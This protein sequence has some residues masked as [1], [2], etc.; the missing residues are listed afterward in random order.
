MFKKSA[1]ASDVSRIL[2]Y[3]A[4]L[5]SIAAMVYLAGPYIAFGD[6]RPLENYLV[7]DIV[8][9]LLIAAFAGFSGVALWKRR[10]NAEALEEGI[11]EGETPDDSE[12][13][14][15]RM[16]DALATLKTASGGKADF[17]Y[18]LPW[19]VIIGPP[20]SGKTTALINSGLRFPLSNGATPQAI[21]GAG[22]TRYCDWWF[23]EE[24]VLIDT[25]GRY[26]TQDSDV[27]A[28]KKSWLAFLQL[29][30]KSRPNQPINGVL[31]AI[32]IQD[33]LLLSKDEIA[34]HTRAIRSRLIEIYDELKVDFPVYVLFTKAD[35]VAGFLEYFANF[36]EKDRRQVWGATFQTTDKTK[37]LVGQV[38]AE[39]DGLVNRLNEQMLDRLQEEPAPGPR[40][41]LYGLPAQMAA[42]KKPI[43]D[44]LNAIFEPTRYHANAT[45]RGFYFA[46]GTQEGTPIDQLIVALSRNFGAREVR[47]SVLSGLGKSFFLTDLLQKVIFGE[48]AWV[49]TDAKALL[50]RRILKFVAIGLAVGVAGAACAAWSIS[51][52]RNM[53]L[54]QSV[55]DAG[56]EYKITAGSLRSED[57]VGDRDF[58][59]IEP[60]L[61]KLRF[62]PAG[63]AQK[64]TEVP[65]AES[66]GLSQRPRLTSSAV[67]AYRAGLER[68]YRPRLLYRLEEVI[69]AKHDDPNYVYEALKV[70][71]MLGGLHAPDKEFIVSWMRQDWEDNLHPGA[72]QA[73]GRMALE[74][75]LR[76]M[77]DLDD[78]RPSLVELSSSVLDDSQRIL[79]RLSIAQRAYQLLKSNARSL[80]IPDWNAKAAGGFDSESVFEAASGG[81]L[82]SIRVPGFFT[83]A[84]F[85]QGLLDRLGTVADQARNEKWVLGKDAEQSAVASQYESV[86]VDVYQLY[87][88]E[89]VQ[90]WRA[91]L[92]KLRLRRLTADKPRYATLSTLAGPSSPL[93]ALFESIRDETAL[94]RERP[95]AKKKAGEPQAGAV[96]LNQPQIGAPGS[97][98]EAQ[99]RP[100]YEWLEGGA[101]TRPIDQLIGRLNE[102]KDN[103]IVSASVPAQ[104]AQANAS[105]QAEL[106]GLRSQTARLPEPFAAMMTRA[107]GSFESDV[108]NSE[109]AQLT[110][111]LG[112]QVTGVCQQIVTGRYPVD[113]SARSEIA[114]ADFGRLFMPNGIFDRFFQQYFAK[115]ADT[116]KRL[117]NWRAD[118]AFA[119]TLSATTLMQFQRAAQIRDAFFATGGSM[120]AINMQ[121]FPP[122][123]S[124]AGVTARF[125][126]NGFAV[127][128]QAGTSVL[129]GAIQWPGAAAGGRA[130][131]TLSVD[132]Q[133][134]QSMIPGQAPAPAAPPPA[135]AVL[136]KTGAWSLFRLLDA[137]GASQRGDR[138]VASFIVGGRELQ[139][140]FAVGT[141]VN[142]FTL[143]ALREFRCPTGL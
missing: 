83:Y 1:V 13:L 24:A 68:L 128:T 137:A 119:R 54:A 132:P 131:V 65:M 53:A 62:M 130:A 143:S 32:S 15:E 43:H 103:L 86:G 118:S 107:A 27:R 37:N 129:P 123:L 95:N 29:L 105:L 33:L 82:V 70:Y 40:V 44:F 20:G 38:P 126:V 63:Y 106:Q 142:P 19:Y 3:G 35:L 115:Y 22:G 93:R 41:A 140:Q 31:V 10:K 72:G 25:A 42:L 127:V 77:L 92:S 28:D 89:F 81:D 122:V 8:I 7:R 114:L 80:K 16:K 100:I 61:R 101:T 88:Q 120:P 111:A 96:L 74:D 5:G 34:A 84:G 94:T 125:E 26:T 141:S 110:R 75:H 102:I 59:K 139:Y 12:T 4:G 21:A 18:D 91:A 71:M 73:S 134:A 36:D 57:L 23:T 51:Y 121:V 87:A 11:G 46:S 50:R 97:Q 113:H 109:L 17:L 66:F 45:L 99:F 60:L 133:P 76:A 104:A 52:S 30:K 136:E 85:Q 9:V 49:S 69:D 64:D 14:K 47:G 6:F 79:A 58:Q 135:P 78:G 55:A 138:L 116:S 48:A 112:D 90:S 39:F 124:G 2:L 67:D 98:I 108:N 117:W 56:N